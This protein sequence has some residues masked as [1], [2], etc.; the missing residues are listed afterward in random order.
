MRFFIALQR[1]VMLMVW[2]QLLEILGGGIVFSMWY[3]G[4]KFSYWESV[5]VWWDPVPSPVISRS[6][7]GE[8]TSS[9]AS[10]FCNELHYHLLEVTGMKKHGFEPL[11]H[12]SEKKHFILLWFSQLHSPNYGK[13]TST[14][15][16]HRS[17]WSFNDHK[18]VFTDMHIHIHVMLS[19]T[20]ES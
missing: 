12:E 2:P 20:Q 14:I 1:P 6:Q 4:R 3:N 18:C 5:L 17:N 15:I 13:L 9:A 16:E 19:H 11:C 10:F 7:W 8:Q